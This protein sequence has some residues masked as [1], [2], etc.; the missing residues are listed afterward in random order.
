MDLTLSISESTLSEDLGVFSKRY[1]GG[2][3]YRE[4]AASDSNKWPSLSV[5][6]REWNAYKDSYETEIRPVVF[7]S[8]I[9]SEPFSS[10]YLTNGLWTKATFAP[11]TALLLPAG[12]SLRTR[13]GLNGNK[14]VKSLTLCL[15]SSTLDEVRSELPSTARR[16]DVI[17]HSSMTND[18]IFEASG[19]SLLRAYNAG[20]PDFYAQASANWLAAYLLLGSRKAPAW[21]RDLSRE[22]IADYR[23]KRVIEYIE[24]NVAKKLDLAALSKEAGVSP[25]HFSA[26]FSKAVGTTPRRYVQ[27]FRMQIARTMLVSTRKTVFEIALST[28]Y[29]SAAH[30]GSMFRQDC[31]QTP[32]EYRATHSGLQ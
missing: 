30:F 23:L 12:E 15:P 27:D 31:G 16:S 4:L 11:G 13:Y 21:H 24:A 20:A 3:F 17:L 8:V 28:G 14:S 25:F 6:L 18:P 22:R 29:S 9:L 7:I 1:N 26:L 10:E 32:T 2:P 5:D 19:R